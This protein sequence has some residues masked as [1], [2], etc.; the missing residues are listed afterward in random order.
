MY[1]LKECKGRDFCV[2]LTLSLQ[3]DTSEIV[4][5]EV[6][7]FREGVQIFVFLKLT[8]MAY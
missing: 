4:L 3:E 7:L 5:L 1:S 6:P 2:L 8:D